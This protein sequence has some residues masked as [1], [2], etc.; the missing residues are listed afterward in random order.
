MKE[1]LRFSESTSL[2]ALLLEVDEERLDDW[3]FFV[4]GGGGV[5]QLSALLII[6]IED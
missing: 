5:D 6:V 1:N 4:V 3:R 2:G